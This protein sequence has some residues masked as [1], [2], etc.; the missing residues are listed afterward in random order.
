[1]DIVLAYDI[2][3]QRVPGLAFFS[4]LVN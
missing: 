3:I 1:M 2:S 4:A